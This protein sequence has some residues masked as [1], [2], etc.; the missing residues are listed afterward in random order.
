MLD[1]AEA[2]TVAL[3]TGSAERVA[4]IT[5]A[6]EKAGFATHRALSDAQPQLDQIHAALPEASLGCYVQLPTIDLDVEEAVSAAGLRA[7]MANALVARFDAL[8]VVAGLLAPGAG[9]VIVAGARTGTPRDRHLSL[10]GISGLLAEAVL[11]SHGA[12]NVRATVVRED[13]TPADIAAIARDRA[14]GAIAR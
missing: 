13:R 5:P 6:L 9:V 2:P 4:G 8:A 1:R 3:V 10:P 12:E 14:G 11:A 7:L